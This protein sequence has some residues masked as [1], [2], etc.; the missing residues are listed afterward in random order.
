MAQRN[1]HDVYMRVIQFQYRLFIFNSVVNETL[2]VFVHVDCC[3]KFHYFWAIVLIAALTWSLCGHGIFFFFFILIA[4]Y[5]FSKIGGQWFWSWIM[6]WLQLWYL[7][8]KFV[9][10]WNWR[11]LRLYRRDFVLST[12]NCSICRLCLFLPV[13]SIHDY[14]TIPSESFI[15][16][17]RSPFWPSIWLLICR[18]GLGSI[19]HLLFS[20][21]F[22]KLSQKL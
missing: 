20:F 7:R 13:K 17:G 2:I 4:C 10:L 22:I 8:S 6:R 19:C 11:C 5:S 1:L 21:K 9:R 14:F 18:Y 15:F 16:I 12:S 3:Q